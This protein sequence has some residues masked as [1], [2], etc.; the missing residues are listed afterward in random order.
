MVQP[1]EQI[2]FYTL[3]DFRA[4]HMSGNSPIYRGEMIVCDRCNF[5]CPYCRGL[6]ILSENCTGDMPLET[7]MSVLETW[8]HQR[9][10]NVRFSGGEPTLYPHLNQL[11]RF[12]RENC[13]QRIAISTNGSNDIAVYRQLVKD[14]VN[15]FSISLDACCA[16]FGD[17]MAGKQGCWQKVVDNIR[18]LSKWVYVTVG[19]VVTQETASSVG[20]VI[21]FAHGLGVADIRIISAAQWNEILDGIGEIDDEILDAH[22]I[23]KYRLTNFKAGRNVR[24]ISES[25]CHRCHLVKD[26]SVVAGRWHYPCVIYMRE[27]GKAIGE[28]GPDMRSDRMEWFRQHNSYADPICRKNCLDICLQFNSRVEELQLDT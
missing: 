21:R 2:G 22:P 15:D 4:R 23:L 25:D 28:V 13:V 26:D 8:C 1:L 6:T 9:L 19:V 5:S 10:K 24:G 18:E 11:V 17:K 14:G 27:G 3:S 12:C 20:D 16:S 7:A